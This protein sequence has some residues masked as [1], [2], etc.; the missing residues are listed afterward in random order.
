[1]PTVQQ[2]FHFIF[3][4]VPDLP[5]ALV[6]GRE[7][8][9]LKHFYDK[10]AVNSGAITPADLDHYTLIYSQPRALRCA[11]AVYEA[12]DRDAT[13]NRAWVNQHG[14]CKVPALAFSGSDSAHAAEAEEMV[15]EMYENVEVAEVAQSGHYVAEENPEDFVKKVLAF[16]EK[17]NSFQHA[18]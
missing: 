9:Y 15:R 5:E 2:Q 16:I 7:K 11:F 12:F 18:G 1:M 10:L 6:T 3:H 14:K 13:D 8:I 17:H 4:S